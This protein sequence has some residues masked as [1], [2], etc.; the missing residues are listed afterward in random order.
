VKTF[1]VPEID[2]GFRAAFIEGLTAP[3]DVELEDRVIAE[4][5]DYSKVSKHNNFKRS[6]ELKD[7]LH[8]II[9]YFMYA[10][11]ALMGIFS[12]IWAWHLSTPP[13]LH[14]LPEIQ[15]DKLQ[16]FIFSGTIS[17]LLVNYTK[18]QID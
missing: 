15:I 4:G 13:A 9:I 16:S 2:L 14:F 8:K 17:A 10:Y 12:I 18:K 6:E 7:H 5:E 11:L 3:S 1:N